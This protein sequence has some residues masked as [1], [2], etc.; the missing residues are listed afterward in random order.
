MIECENSKR[1]A[2]HVCINIDTIV[3]EQKKISAAAVLWS[4][5]RPHCA[6][7]VQEYH[8]YIQVGIECKISDG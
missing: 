7:V 5:N 8:M 4:K 2:V 6:R 3:W 1:A